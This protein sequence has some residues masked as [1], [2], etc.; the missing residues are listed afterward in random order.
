M[1]CD[2][3]R[4]CVVD[5]LRVGRVVKEEGA[6]SL[7]SRHFVGGGNEGGGR[8]LTTDKQVS[9]LLLKLL[10]F[11][12]FSLLLFLALHL[13]TNSPINSRLGGSVHERFEA[14]LLDGRQ[15]FV[16]PI[17]FVGNF[18]VHV[19]RGHIL[20]EHRRVILDGLRVPSVPLK[21]G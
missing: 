12:H 3:L 5:L 18:R 2:Q 17:L 7:C 20:V 6:V 14:F 11:V 1:I 10:L 16:D 15:I 19:Q 13:E 4:S 21:R 8:K 9:L